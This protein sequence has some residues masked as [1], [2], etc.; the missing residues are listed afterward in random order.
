MNENVDNMEERET[1]ISKLSI[2][3][4][5]IFAIV[6]ITIALCVFLEILAVKT[7][8]ICVAILLPVSF[9]SKLLYHIILIFRKK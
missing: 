5:I 6:I 7:L 8:L 3:V 4:G 1:G 9:F 2:W